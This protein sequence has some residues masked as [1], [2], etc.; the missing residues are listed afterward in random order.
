MYSGARAAR[1]LPALE[2]EMGKYDK[3]TA[4]PPTIHALLVVVRVGFIHFQLQAGLPQ[5]AQHIYL[6]LANSLFLRAILRLADAETH[7]VLP[8]GQKK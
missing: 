2:G 3:A 8:Y 4:E 6:G 1:L 7:D 5:L